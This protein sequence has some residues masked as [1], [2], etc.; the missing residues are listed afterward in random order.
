MIGKFLLTAL[1]VL[2]LNS[3]L[4][5]AAPVYTDEAAGFKISMPEHIL[6]ITGKSFVTLASDSDKN[7]QKNVYLVLSLDQAEVKK[8][9][10]EEFSTAQFKKKTSDLQVL[11][12]NKIDPE[13]VDYKIFK[14]ETFKAS[15]SNTWKVLPEGINENNSTLTVGKDKLKNFVFL[16]ATLKPEQEVSTTIDTGKKT[17]Q[18]KDNPSQNVQMALTSAND[19]LYILFTSFPANLPQNDKEEHSIFTEK[20][21]AAADKQAA[22]EYERKSQEE[23]EN[24]LSSFRTFAPETRKAPY[25]FRDKISG[26]QIVLPESWFYAIS[27]QKEMDSDI[28]LSL[29]FPS[30][31]LKT[32]EGH[33]LKLP[34]KSA[35]EAADKI[36]ATDFTAMTASDYK[37]EQ[38]F[39]EFEEAIA[40]I[41]YKSHEKH[42]SEY[43]KNPNLTKLTIMSVINALLSR[44]KV[45]NNFDLSQYQPL[46]E[47]NDHNGYIKLAGQIGYK[48]KNHLTNL[49]KINFDA[50]KIIIASYLA[51]GE[52]I[53][54]PELYQAM[55]RITL[56]K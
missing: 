4:A 50:D 11:T 44:D 9:T 33:L 21:A 2:A 1:A 27:N 20:K 15:D 22:S 37:A 29:A 24:F 32:V 14:P 40:I 17:D 47:V 51:N 38:F 45:K 28:S 25:G 55:E 13:K 53:K 34:V 6:Q 3:G 41:S 31:T 54:T 36:T 49:T 46:V 16:N 39:K 26:T 42:F 5:L 12:R 8:L 19:R 23:R 56:A 52:Q 35:V 7:N 18:A 48:E 10:G 30:S 43:L